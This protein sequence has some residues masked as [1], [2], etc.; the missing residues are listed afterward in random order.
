M[1]CSL[2]FGEEVGLNKL[3][4]CGHNLV[5][6]VFLCFVLFVFWFYPRVEMKSSS[7][8]NALIYGDAFR[9][10]DKAGSTQ[11]Q[12]SPVLLILLASS[13]WPGQFILPQTECLAHPAPPGPPPRCHQ[14]DRCPGFLQPPKLLDFARQLLKTAMQKT[15]HNLEKETF[16][17][18]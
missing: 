6:S 7:M 9:C 8:W 2:R 10:L 14:H 18:I 5:S 11:L 1:T 16:T 12:V 4:T 3:C 17:V 15:R 13:R